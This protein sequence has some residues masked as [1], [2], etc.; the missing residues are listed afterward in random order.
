MY[1]LLQE[2]MMSDVAPFDYSSVINGLNLTIDSTSE[3]L[4]SVVPA[5]H[6][7]FRKY[8]FKPMCKARNLL[9]K[10]ICEHKLPFTVVGFTYSGVVIKITDIKL[11]TESELR[12]LQDQMDQVLKNYKWLSINFSKDAYNSSGLHG[13]FTVIIDDRFGDTKDTTAHFTKLRYFGINYATYAT[14]VIN[15]VIDL[16]IKKACK[17]I[18]ITA[19]VR[20][21]DFDRYEM[22]FSLETP[23][24]IH[25]NVDTNFSKHVPIQLLSPFNYRYN[26]VINLE[27]VNYR[28][29]A[30]N[31]IRIILDY[32][33]QE[34]RH[35]AMID[36]IG[37]E[38][39][40]CDADLSLINVT[41]KFNLKQSIFTNIHRVLTKYLKKH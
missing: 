28:N 27:F 17:N 35:S 41:G 10:L 32:Y 1:I 3:K 20:S 29:K 31:G 2:R 30:I 12:K 5:L 19:D 34:L 6:E 40:V 14:K 26:Q 39:K 33:I 37:I 23:D 16:A 9:K 8:T 22:Q 7:A 25:A 38:Y 36:E 21:K 15:S 11:T 24:S 18:F 13:Y 4:L